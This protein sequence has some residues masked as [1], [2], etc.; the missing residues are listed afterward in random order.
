MNHFVAWNFIQLQMKNCT[1]QIIITHSPYPIPQLPHHLQ[2]ALSNIWLKPRFLSL[3]RVHC[4][5]KKTHIM[6]VEKVYFCAQR[7]APGDPPGTPH[8]LSCTDR[9]GESTRQRSQ[10]EEPRGLHLYSLC[11]CHRVMWDLENLSSLL[12]TS[13]F[14]GFLG[15]EENKDPDLGKA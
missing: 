14:T 5:Q 7:V 1:H 2:H 15:N 12:T 9:L 13:G 8:L 11:T 6:F 4:H 10:I 3:F